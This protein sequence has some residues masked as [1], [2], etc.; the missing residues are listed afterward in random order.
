MSKL[1]I[2][3]HYFINVGNKLAYLVTEGIF[4][5][6]QQASLFPTF[7]SVIGKNDS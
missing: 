3:E 2:T 1:C 4:T 6:S 7:I 5:V